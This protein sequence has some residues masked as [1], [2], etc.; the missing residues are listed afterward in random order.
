MRK[1]YL[2]IAMFCSL[3]GQAPVQAIAQETRLKDIARVEGVRD[4]ALIGYGVIVGLQG[5]GDSPAFP[6]TN[7]T[8][9]NML[10]RLG[11][12]GPDQVIRSRN[13]AAVTVTAAL[14]PFARPGTRVD[15]S[16]ALMGDAVSLQGGVLQPTAL[17]GPDGQVYATAEGPVSLGGGFAAGGAGQSV[18]RGVVSTARISGGAIV[19]RAP[20]F[21][22]SAQQ[23]LTLSL[24]NPDFSLARNV[25]QIVNAR[26]GQNVARMKDNANIEIAVPQSYAGR[27]AELVADIENLPLRPDQPGPNQSGPPARIV[28]DE[29]SGTIVLGEQVRLST[30][31]VS[32][33]GV[34]VRVTETPQVS[35]PAPFSS[36]GRTVV[37]PR[38]NIE[39]NG[40][41]GRLVTL[42]AGATIGDLVVEDSP[43]MAKLLRAILRGLAVGR[44]EECTKP[45]EVI[46]YVREFQPDIIFM[47]LEMPELDGFGVTKELRTGDES[48][49]P[50]VPIVMVTAH[51]KRADVVQARD[52]GITEF[53]AKPVSAKSVYDHLA[54]CIETP[55]PFIK[56]KTYYGPDRR[57]RSDGYDGPERRRSKMA[58][59][60]DA[61]K[62]AT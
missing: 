52:S 36:G 8:L 10:N 26:L 18:A 49:N 14:P 58:K 39:V 12:A 50:F 32:Q 23:V 60:A 47:D 51:T 59:G 42:P 37:V 44:V 27:A 16:I 61:A 46:S 13:A 53:L 17:A 11:V 57:R 43:F 9:R 4:N 22:L 6:T 35:Q 62:A 25:A 54:A 29:R 34:T 5:T 21:D 19:E 56:T 7:A 41:G 48:P 40:G 20:A 33:S 24:L 45:T 55:R 31:A 2:L 3:A 1:A 38:T 30:V 15:I 28:I